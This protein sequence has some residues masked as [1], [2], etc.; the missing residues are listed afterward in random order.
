MPTKRYRLE[1]TPQAE[2][3]RERVEKYAVELETRSRRMIALSKAVLS[4]KSNW[5]LCLFFDREC[6]I[7]ICYIEGWYSVFFTVDESAG[8]IIVLAILG[9]AEDLER[10][11]A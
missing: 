8:R 9:Q 11:L 7:R 4:L 3:D 6:S 1:I 10:L 5:H 2:K